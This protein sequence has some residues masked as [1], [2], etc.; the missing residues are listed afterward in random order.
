MRVFLVALALAA[1]G[2]SALAGEDKDAGR[3]AS[4]AS[5][6]RETKPT[7]A[8]VKS[9]P[10]AIEEARERNVAIFLHSHAN[11][12]PP[13]KAIAKAV[14]ED[15]DYVKWANTETIHVLSYDIHADADPEPLVEVER[16]G[17]K[18]S[19]YAHYP[20]FTPDELTMLLAEI[21]K[22]VDFPLHTPWAGVLSPDGKKVLAEIAKGTAKDFRAAY[23][24]GQKTLGTP[25]P[26]A[27]W[28]KVRTALKTSMDA[29]FDARWKDAAAAALEA[30]T[31]GAGAPDALQE[32]ID[33]RMA[34]VL[35]EGRRLLAEAKK[36][37]DAAA[38]EKAVAKVREDF[39]GIPL[40]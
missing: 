9:F 24:K 11:T 34:S 14:F 27:T 17:A 37:K 22:R 18:V 1:L 40:D 10:D 30:K 5:G 2:T 12:C 7:I 35:N 26:R 19:V 36:T 28:M 13:C 21:G 25:Y 6:K 23:E 29:E 32:S 31:V 15:P 39:A 8:W 16:D 4:K 33:A 38:A 3:T 20:M